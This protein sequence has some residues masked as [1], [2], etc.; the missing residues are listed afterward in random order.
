MIQKKSFITG[1]FLALIIS[2]PPTAMAA[3]KNLPP[4]VI[5]VQE[6]QQDSQEPNDERTLATVPDISPVLAAAMRISTEAKQ[7]II[8]DYHT[9]R[10]LY[11]KNADRKMYPSSMTKIMTAY[12]VFDRM[13]KGILSPETPVYV[14][15]KAWRT[16][17]SRMY[18]N[19]NSQ[20]PVMDL[21]HG[22]IIQSGND[23]CVALA[24]ALS[25]T[26]EVFSAE[27][28]QKAAELGCTQTNFRNA[29]G[30]PDLEHTTTARDLSIIARRIISDF[31]EYYAVFG[32]KEYTHNNITQ[33]NRNPLLDK[34][35][36]CDGLKTGFTDLGQHGLVA[37]AREMTPDGNEK[38]F[39]IVVNGLPSEKVR[40]AE[41]LKLMTW[42][43]KTFTTVPIAKKGQVIA[44]MDVSSGAERSVGLTLAQDAYATFPNIAKNDVRT[45]LV[46]DRSVQAPIQEGQVLGKAIITVPTFETPLEV[47]LIA[48]K[49]IE[50]AGIFKRIWNSIYHIF[51]GNA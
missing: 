16:G 42:A 19:V 44:N 22:V 10:V 47:D 29:S 26:E 33:P 2:N 36:G 11:E 28:N 8:L 15:E 46:Y 32:Q 13:K 9:G 50:R 5:K 43:L 30:L 39:I 35:I 20:V 27:M 7:A 25:G 21:L 1:L 34:N 12:M 51:G 23:A 17:G 37:S 38:R 3:K 31:P 40:A 41:S 4:K 14:S 6:K 48:N 18:I 24:E 45:E 49:N